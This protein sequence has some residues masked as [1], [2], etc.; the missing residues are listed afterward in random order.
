MTDDATLLRR[1]AD[2][3]SE[4]AFT[5]LVRRHLDMVFGAALRRTGGDAH[6]AA[7]VVQEVFTALA[8]QA[9][10][11]THHTVLSA[12]LHTATRNRAVNLMT[13]ERRRK[14]REVAAMAL[15]PPGG[16]DAA[17][18]WNEVRPTLD[19]AIDELPE[20]DRAAVVLRFLE[21]RPFTE[22]GAVFD[23]SADAARM[24]TER[25]LERLRAA[26]ARRGITSTAAALGALV[27]TH[28]GVTAPA[29]LATTVASG[30]LSG[31]AGVFAPWIAT[32]SLMGTKTI[33]SVVTV[34]AGL[35]VG[36]YLARDHSARAPQPSPSV[37]ARPRQE[38]AAVRQESPRPPA[39]PPRV[40]S[41]TTTPALA[42][43]S[44][45]S[46]QPPPAALP[47]VTAVNQQRAMINNLRQ[48]SAAVKQ[49]QIENQ[50]APASLDELVGLTKYIRQLNAVDGESYAGVLLQPDQPM[51][52]VTP[53]GVAVTY[54]PA[55]N[56]TTDTTAAMRQAQQ[57]AQ[58]LLTERFGVEFVQRVSASAQ[59]AGA[60]Y[61][62]AHGGKSPPTPEA[63]LVYFETPE[64]G[65]DFLEFAEAMKALGITR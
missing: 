31:A 3:K 44:V 14:C 8:R 12:W 33:V 6:R 11:L 62:A 16:G 23:I 4:A 61:A 41:A 53:R 13:S 1:F 58:R 55:G 51:T 35:G 32:L 26:L 18:D 30:A 37:P 17:L 27:T 34:V 36:I 49:F 7:D 2:E 42:P 5:E 47:A 59:K 28:S 21:R 45:P 10:S 39:S 25:A 65:A 63:A 22:I 54:D 46:V 56:L 48:L 38:A 40:A 64:A 60:A 29:G 9:C 43:R 15:E 57:E 24:R 19:A 52:V 50:R 20:S